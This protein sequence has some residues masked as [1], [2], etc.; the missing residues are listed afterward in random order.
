MTVAIRPVLLALA[1][2]LASAAPHYAR[3]EVPGAGTGPAQVASVWDK[4][5]RIRQGDSSEETREQDAPAAPAPAARPPAPSPEPPAVT[6]SSAQKPAVKRQ[7]RVTARPVSAPRQ[8]V[9]KGS[10]WAY[11]LGALDIDSKPFYGPYGV[12]FQWAYARRDPLPSQPR[13]VVSLHA[14]GE[15]EMGV[16]APTEMGDIEVRNRDAGSYRPDWREGWSVG[17]DGQPYPARRIAATLQFLTQRYQIE[18]GERGIVLEGSS[19]GGTGALLQTMLLPQPW[20]SRIAYVSARAGVVM[21]RRVARKH[22]QQYP[23]MPPDS[24]AGGQVWEQI[25]FA[26]QAAADPVVRGIHYRH[27]FSSDDQLSDGPLGNTQLEFV[28]L[29][30]RHRI[31]AAF[32]WVKGGH[33]S[34]ERGVRMPDLSRFEAPEQD[35]TLDRAHPAITRSTGNYP[36]SARERVDETAFPRGHYNLGITWDHAGIIDS[37][38]EI[39]FPLR[40]TAHANFGRG[41][42][43]Q[44]RR[45]TVSVTPRRPRHF[46]LRDGETLNWSWNDG[47]LTG[48]AAVQRDTLTIDG[49]PLLSGEPYRKLRIYR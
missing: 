9:E 40:Y 11:Y 39:V 33:A 1:C 25:D 36:P 18:P 24:G 29:V 14:A 45:I 19:M 13:I 15:G 34:Y 42:P 5:K 17:A 47:A 30:E 46:E 37:P 49:I 7:G 28:N 4:Y 20:R 31:G 12:D 16:F 22:P 32:T 10:W 43:D 2:L 27:V 41:V 44:P 8:P 38:D 21:P 26:V 23:N 48:T 35:V 3:A 6:P